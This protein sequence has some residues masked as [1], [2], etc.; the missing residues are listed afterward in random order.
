[1]IRLIKIMLGAIAF[2]QFITHGASLFFGIRIGTRYSEFRR[3]TT[4]ENINGIYFSFFCLFLLF[5]FD[6]VERYGKKK[7]EERRN[8]IK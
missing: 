2:M 8:R 5:L 1:M 7:D 6:F 4:E 3:Y